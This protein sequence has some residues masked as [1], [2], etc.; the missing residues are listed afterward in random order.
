MPQPDARP[1]S[2]PAAVPGR[3]T[4][5]VGGAATVLAALT[6]CAASGDSDV[7][8]PVRKAAQK[9]LSVVT[10]TDLIVARFADAD[11]PRRTAL[12][13]LADA[14]RNCRTAVEKTYQ[15]RPVDA[16]GLDLCRR[17]LELGAAV[18]TLLAEVDAAVRAEDVDA[19]TTL[20]PTLARRREALDALIN[21]LAGSR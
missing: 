21:E 11:V 6:G 3:R 13:M 20:R 18:R 10:T 19:A 4:L 9:L 1:P 8:G 12:V 14:E 7:A 16:A 2:C 17:V 15:L 5:L